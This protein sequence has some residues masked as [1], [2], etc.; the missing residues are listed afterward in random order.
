MAI[1]EKKSGFGW[2]D[3]GTREY[4]PNFKS[5]VFDNEYEWIHAHSPLSRNPYK[6]MVRING[7]W[8]EV[9]RQKE[10]TEQI[11]KQQ[12]EAREKLERHKREGGSKV[13]LSAPEWFFSNKSVKDLM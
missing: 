6:T 3:D 8:V 10:Q 4:D 1:I 13:N 2:F 12:A 7:I 9:E 11:L 5:T